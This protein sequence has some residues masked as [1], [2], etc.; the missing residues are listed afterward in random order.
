MWPE[1]SHRLP[2][3][4]ALKHDRFSAAF[5]TRKLSPH[6]LVA[7]EFFISSETH[8]AIRTEKLRAIRK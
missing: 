4:R 8:P 3:E 6:C 7:V 2:A 1:R 5:R